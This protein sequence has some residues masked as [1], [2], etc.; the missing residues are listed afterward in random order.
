MSETPPLMTCRLLSAIDR[1]Y[2]FD[3][4]KNTLCKYHGKNAKGNCIAVHTLEPSASEIEFYKGMTRREAINERND[5]RKRLESLLI[6]MRYV[7]WGYKPPKPLHPDLEK[8]LA[9]V[10]NRPPYSVRELGLKLNAFT[11]DHLTRAET[12]EAFLE[13]VDSRVCDKTPLFKVLCMSRKELTALNK[14]RKQLEL[15]ERTPG[16]TPA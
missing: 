1:V 15:A 6:L 3:Q 9:T 5:S 4:C 14:L 13:K 11:L 8:E 2:A 7:E 10:L 12:W 16:E